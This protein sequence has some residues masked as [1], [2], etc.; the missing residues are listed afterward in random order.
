ML[1]LCLDLARRTGLAYGDTAGAKP[2]VE[3]WDLGAGR[4]GAAHYAGV[5]GYKLRQFMKDNARPERF[6]VEEYMA[7]TASKNQAATESQLLLHG[8]LHAIGGIFRIPVTA[9]RVDIARKHF[10]G[11]ASALPR[12]KGKATPRQKAE[13]RRAT[14]LMV[15]ERAKLL[16]Y[17]PAACADDNMADACALY[18]W[19]MTNVAREAPGELRLF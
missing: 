14:K 18:D 11:R 6:V 17:L 4:D 12:Q 5:L 1:I 7:P 9:V 15:L 2:R 19:A 13:A 3:A 16:G 10:C 8:A